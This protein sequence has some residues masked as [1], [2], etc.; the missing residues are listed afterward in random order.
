MGGKT[1]NGLDV[2]KLVCAVM[3]LCAHFASTWGHFPALLDFGFSIYV[4]AVPFF[5]A[6]SGFLL[7]EKL[8]RMEA[9]GKKAAVGKYIRH[10]AMM[11][12]CWSA[13]YFVFVLIG[14]MQ[15]KASA[16]VMLAYFHRALVF[17][18]YATIWFLPA[19]LVGVLAV[20][21]LSK[22][23]SLQVVLAIGLAFYLA[24]TLGYSYAF[25]ISGCPRME[26]LYRLHDD[27]FITT[28]NGVFNGFPFVALG[29]WISTREK[30]MPLALSGTLAFLSLAL[31]AGE[32]VALKVGF[33][34][35][36]V[37]TALALVPFTFFF[38]EFLLALKLQ[39][40]K[41]YPQLREMSTM[42]FLS[43]RLFITALPSILPAAWAGVAFGNSYLGLGLTLGLT[44]AL[45]WIFI[46]ASAT[47]PFLK[48]FR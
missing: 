16:G 29:A 13:V 24:G 4:I 48:V 14:W 17:T 15:D 21:F 9:E 6:C 1:Y 27:I 11:Y 31:V 32:A 41:I 43:Q 3:I 39:D 28:R 23:L 34:V 25:L 44:A 20:Y 7:F 40:R 36:G 8:G 18:T 5:F 45:S 19:L 46:R 42:I 26:S 38:M 33:G 2:A 37:D 22:K 10:I 12:L 47:H 35:R 30:R